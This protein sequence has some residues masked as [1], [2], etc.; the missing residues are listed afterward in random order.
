MIMGAVTMGFVTMRV[1]GHGWAL[2][3][4]RLTSMPS[5]PI[6]PSPYELGKL[7]AFHVLALQLCQRGSRASSVFSVTFK[8]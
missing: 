4:G 3:T 6:H 2:T 5:V 8:F 7:E 1:Y